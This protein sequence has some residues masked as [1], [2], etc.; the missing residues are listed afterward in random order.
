MCPLR[1]QVH[2]HSAD[3][4][5]RVGS[6]LTVLDVENINRILDLLRRNQDVYQNASQIAISLGS[7]Q[8]HALRLSQNI[9]T[10]ADTLT[11]DTEILAQTMSNKDT[12]HVDKD[13]KTLVRHLQWY[14]RMLGQSRV[15]IAGLNTRVLGQ[16]IHDRLR[17]CNV[18][19]NKRDIL[20][21]DR[22]SVV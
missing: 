3:I 14:Q 11:D 6:P 10:R 8:Q 12:P 19:I 1:S 17:G 5:M 15:Q 21:R 7:Q 2:N 9:L 16:I 18:V 22:K 4:T 13:S 20:Q